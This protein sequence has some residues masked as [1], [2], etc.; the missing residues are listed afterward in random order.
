MQSVEIVGLQEGDVFFIF[1]VRA[2]KIIGNPR[3]I[4]K[5]V[6]GPGLAWPK[7]CWA[8]S[9]VHA[10]GVEADRATPDSCHHQTQMATAG[11]WYRTT[12][13]YA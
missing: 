13:M 2:V 1:K 5:R 4:W 8:K 3:F 10:P 12:S 7:I 6:T 11:P 9:S